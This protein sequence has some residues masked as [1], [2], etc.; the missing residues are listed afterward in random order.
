MSSNQALGGKYGATK[1]AR[2]LVR[3]LDDFQDVCETVVKQVLQFVDSDDLVAVV[4]SMECS[5]MP[6]P[7]TV[8]SFILGIQ[9]PKSVL[10][11]Q[12]VRN[13]LLKSTMLE[14]AVDSKPAIIRKNNVTII[15]R[16]VKSFFDL[17]ALYH[18]LKTLSQNRA[19]ALKLASARRSARFEVKTIEDDNCN[20]DLTI[21][22]PGTLFEERSPDQASPEA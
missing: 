4:K 1:L 18:Q 8:S 6:L 17:F 13:K 19:G 14:D 5:G 16:P 3:S 12:R 11:G 22:F 10:D 9:T 21:V 20:F 2:Y 7:N 15:S